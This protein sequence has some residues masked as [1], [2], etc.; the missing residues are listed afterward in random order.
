MTGISRRKTC[1]DFVVTA[2]TRATIGFRI[3]R[4]YMY[5]L[6][7]SIVRSMDRERCS[8]RAVRFAEKWVKKVSRRALGLFYAYVFFCN[9]SKRA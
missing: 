7:G 5:V 4:I 9:G 8:R 2:V 1:Y 6:V 3:R